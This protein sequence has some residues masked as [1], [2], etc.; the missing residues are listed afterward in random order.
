MSS[1]Y[2]NEMRLDVEQAKLEYREQSDRACADDERV[3]LDRFSLGQQ[4]N[5]LWNLGFL[6]G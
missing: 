2:A 3:G 6:S 1:Q 4:G 5:Y